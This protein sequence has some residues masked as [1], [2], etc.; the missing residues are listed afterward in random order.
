LQAALHLTEKG[1]ACFPCLANK[2][3]ACP[4]GFKDA[5]ADKEGV[6]AL[7]RDYPGVLIGVP[8]GEMFVVLDL[9]FKHVTAQHGITQ[10]RCR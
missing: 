3:P 6:W 7:W 5:K 10:R 9:D 1:I 4:H 2:R 8:T